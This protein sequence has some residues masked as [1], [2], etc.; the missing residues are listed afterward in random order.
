MNNDLIQIAVLA[1]V[2][3]FV[4]FRLY[5]TLGKRSGA[6]RSDEPHPQPAQG[7][8]GSIE[9]PPAPR[10][11]ADVQGPASA[12]I[13]DIVRADPQ[14]E[15]DRFL[16]GARGAYE[17]IVSAFGKGDMAALEPFVTA[18]IAAIYKQAIDDRTAKGEAGPEL[19]RLRKAELVDADLDGAMAR[20]SVR[21]EAEL[22]HGA[23]GVRDAKERWTFERDVRSADPNWVLAR[24]SAA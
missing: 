13:M 10:P 6:E 9:Q 19:V 14:F 20:I 4:L 18:R 15:A 2:A 11:V 16:A 3:A 23:T 21:F 17:L 12:G 1:F 22:A 24:V 7:P 5:S 8:L